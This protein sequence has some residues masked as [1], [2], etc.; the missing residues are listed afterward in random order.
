[1]ATNAQGCSSGS[2]SAT[3]DEQAEAALG[4]ATLLL[5]GLLLPPISALS[6][7]RRVGEPGLRV[8]DEMPAGALCSMRRLDATCTKPG[9]SGDLG[10]GSR[11][12]GRAGPFVLQDRV[13]RAACIDE[14]N[15]RRLIRWLAKAASTEGFQ[16]MGCGGPD[17]AA[18]WLP[19]LLHSALWQSGANAAS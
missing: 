11:P 18:C 17:A 10:A 9:G 19:L 2:L 13:W 8:E 3:G 12:G 14:G 4:A 7:L 6:S 15:A 5:P 1:M 16:M